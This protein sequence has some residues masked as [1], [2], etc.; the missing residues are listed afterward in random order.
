[1]YWLQSPPQRGTSLHRRSVLGAALAILAGLKP[2]QAAKIL[3]PPQELLSRTEP[4]KLVAGLQMTGETGVPLRLEDYRGRIIVLNLWASWC[5]PCR[6]EMPSLSRLS[7]AVDPSAFMVLPVAIERHGIDAVRTFYRKTGISNLPLV[8][9]DGQNV[10][11]VLDAGGL[12]F[13]ILI[14]GEGHEFA[15]VIGAARWDDP[16]FIAWLKAQRLP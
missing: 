3:R 8:L 5:F 10:A 11:A 12:P 16:A 15:R 14:D 9:G 4:R 2:V 7:A 6:D 13:T 1:M